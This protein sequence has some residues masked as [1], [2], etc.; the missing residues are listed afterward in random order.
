M[1]RPYPRWLPTSLAGP[2]QGLCVATLLLLL[3]AQPWTARAALTADV[4]LV[5][6]TAAAAAVAGLVART[7]TGTRRTICLA[8]AIA[9]SFAFLGRLSWIT[10]ILQYGVTPVRPLLEATTGVIMQLALAIGLMSVLARHRHRNWMRFEALIDALL[11]SVAVAMPVVQA[12][13]AMTHNVTASPLL[14]FLA[15]AW[16]IFDAANLVLVTLLL[17]WKGEA[18]GSRLAFG[19]RVRIR[20][21]RARELSVQPD[22]AGG[23]VAHSALGDRSLDADRDDTRPRRRP[24]PVSATRRLAGVADV[25]ERVREG[26]H[27][28]DRHGDPHRL[29]EWRVSRLRR[30]AEP[31][32]RIRAARIRCV[33][34]GS[35][36]ARAIQAA[37]CHRRSGARCR[38]RARTFGRA[39]A[40][41]RPSHGGVGGGAPGAAAHVDAG[42]AD[43]DRAQSDEGAAAIPRGVGGRHARGWRRHRPRERRAY[44]DRDDVRRR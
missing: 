32:A 42:A 38:S 27:L 26:P 20:C 44:R 1:T 18:L 22:R 24:A 36:R 10:Y 16:N 4:L 6:Q 5:V 37:A 2:T 21:A 28:F 15:I 11:L 19:T 41:R 31:P 39:R 7:S 29:L 43:R 33:A 13:L 25:R 40:A 30:R 17:I 14:R 23:R 12:G 3:L 34:R 8:I 35:R 9:S